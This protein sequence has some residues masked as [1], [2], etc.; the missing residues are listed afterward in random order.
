MPDATVRNAG[1]RRNPH[2]PRPA[3][4]LIVAVAALACITALLISGALTS[5][6]VPG[7]PAPDLSVPWLLV[8]TRLLAR[9]AQVATTGALVLA[10]LL[11]SSDGSLSPYGWLACRWAGGC[12]LVWALAQCAVLPLYTADLLSTGWNQLSARMV[13]STMTGLESGRELIAVLGAAALCAVIARC[14]L[15]PTAAAV[16]LSVALLA[17]LPQAAG[18][19]G[20]A[21][22]NHQIAVSSMVLHIGATV[23]WAGGLGA[24]A[25]SSRRLPLSELSVAAARFSRVAA[26]A[27][28]VVIASGMANGVVRLGWPSGRWVTSDYGQL[29]LVKTM[30][31]V[32]AVAAGAA[33][34]HRTLKDLAA[35]QRRAFARL[36]LG[37]AVVF[38]AVLGLAVALSRTPPPG[39]GEVFGV[40]ETLLGF[41]MPPRIT[42]L[43][44]LRD[45]YPEPLFTA[46]ATFALVFYLAAVRRLIRRGDRWPRLR[47]AAWCL[48][49]LVVVVATGSGLARYAPL[50]T[51]VHMLQHLLLSM[52]AA[53]LLVLGAPITLA[54]RA[55]SG[56]GAAS[57][58]GEQGGRARPR[59]LLRK[60]LASAPMRFVGSVWLVWPM[61]ALTPFLVYFTG[62]YGLSLRY[63]FGHLLLSAHF[64]LAA[65]LFF[66]LVL[67]VDPLPGRPSY[68][69][70]LLILVLTAVAHAMFGILF[71][72]G[73]GVA[74]ASSWFA[75]VH[76][77][78]GP[79]RA[80]DVQIAGGLAWA[81]GEIPLVLTLL[82]VANQWHRSDEREQRRRD[83]D[84]KRPGSGTDRAFEEYNAMLRRLAE[85]PGRRD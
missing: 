59:R 14:A 75:I 24:L 47:V 16:A 57:R 80:G 44:V 19:H 56:G 76:P 70:R 21:A 63:H 22:G 41:P 1:R 69:V 84:A 64:L 46:A 35:G 66:N 82:V 74:L 83:R 65:Y 18:G 36:A 68:P 54:L 15:R 9:L 33:H 8:L 53:P 7:I 77:P 50:L 39:R 52:V 37:E 10:L 20:S 25:L 27:A 61:F 13:V 79:T 3:A 11:P 62:I 85:R 73:S 72:Q 71:M 4:G 32:V 49:W 40:T 45:W 78:W 29:M 28:A 26:P 12:A 38:A 55:L 60:A 42:L 58:T 81:F 51:W 6:S 31:A 30:L 23:V 17:V 43:R 67:G 5:V 34:R 2:R 48:G